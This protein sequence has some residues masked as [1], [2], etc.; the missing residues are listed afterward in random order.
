MIQFPKHVLDEIR[1]K[2]DISDYMGLHVDLLKRGD[3]FVG[4]CPFHS[5][6]NPSMRV[7]PGR[8][9]FKC[10]GCGAGGSVITFAMKYHEL[11]FPDA[12]ELLADVADIAL[13]DAEERAKTKEAL[14]FLTEV[15][16]RYRIG[17]GKNLEE[18]LKIPKEILDQYQVGY[19]GD[20]GKFWP[21]GKDSVAEELGYLVNGHAYFKNRI[22]YP[23][24]NSAAQVLGFYGRSI[25]AV[26]IP[27]HRSSKT[28]F[29]FRKSNAAFFGFHQALPHI[30][31][32]KECVL[33]EGPKDLLAFHKFM[34]IKNIIATCGTAVSKRQLWA[35]KNLAR[36]VIIGFDSDPGGVK[37]AL[38]HAAVFLS[39]GLVVKFY[40]LIFD[41]VP[42]NPTPDPYDWFM[43]TRVTGFNPPKPLS[44]IEFIIK[45]IKPQTEADDETDYLV[46]IKQVIDL[47]GAVKNKPYQQILV[48]QAADLLKVKVSF[49]W[50]EVANLNKFWPITTKPIEVL[51]DPWQQLLVGLS[52]QPYH[53]GKV[54]DF[55]GVNYIGSSP[56]GNS[57]GLIHKM[58]EN[59][60]QTQAEWLDFMSSKYMVAP[61]NSPVLDEMNEDEIKEYIEVAT[62]KVVGNT[63]ITQMK[64]A[65]STGDTIGIERVKGCLLNLERQ[66]V[67]D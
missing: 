25:T 21:P 10:F 33:V 49:L 11:S 35:I 56:D 31:E 55:L 24:T 57:S 62:K 53:A 26:E 7:H 12:V 13:P 20:V 37:A 43:S 58:E 27:A 18:E 17:H 19:I 3:S 9:I 64:H 47:I 40:H 23:I 2:I 38:S 54:S 48:E 41:N 67:L 15:E 30:R 1:E 29:L 8:G 42:D 50:D 60:I 4:V 36:T 39:H 34:G 44:P 32:S 28:S 59:K 45:Q 5:D 16:V 61:T 52:Y 6:T 51:T 66:K 22:M 63:L 14:E 65:V 46:N